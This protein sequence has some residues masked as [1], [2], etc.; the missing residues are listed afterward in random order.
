[1]KAMILA[2]GRGERLRPLT[3]SCPKPLL[4]AGEQPL[5]GWHLA[6]LAALG[7]RDIVINHAWLGDQIEQRLDGGAEWGV[8]IAYSVEGGQALETAGGITKALPLLGNEPF[9]VI[10]GDVFT[11]YPLAPL[12]DIA[13]QLDGVSRLGHLVLVD[14]PAHH[15]EGDFSLNGHGVVSEVPGLTFAGIAAYHP[16]FFAGLVPHQPAKLLPQLLGAMRQGRLSGEHYQGL[17]IDVGTVERLAEAN[18]IAGT[19]V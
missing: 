1:M 17:W 12:L 7:I 19:W 8:N 3:D 11:D 6:K 10:N 15:P 18:R 2:A 14:N 5:I 4:Q 13:A 16:A 9:I